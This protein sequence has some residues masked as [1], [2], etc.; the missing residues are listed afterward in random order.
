MSEG[1]AGVE[2]AL[3]RLAAEASAAVAD[4]VA[5][6]VLSDRASGPGRVMAGHLTLPPPPRALH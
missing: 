6:V 2:A 1:E 4:G 3:D 5:V